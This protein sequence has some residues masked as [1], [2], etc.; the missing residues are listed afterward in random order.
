MA[1]TNTYGISDEKILSCTEEKVQ[2][3][4]KVGANCEFFKGH[5]QTF[6]LLPAVGQIAI[7]NRFATQ[8][9]HINKELLSIKKLK[10]T[11]PLLPETNVQLDLSYV[12][13]SGAFS[14]TL[15]DAA[16]SKKIYSTGKIS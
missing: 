1:C 16:D 6:K 3:V 5:F 8:Y 12:K 4:F 2:I 10:F 14:F 15:S 9:L 7:V 11:A 13:D